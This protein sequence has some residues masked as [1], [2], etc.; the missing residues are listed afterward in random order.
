[1][2]GRFW[3][4]NGIFGVQKKWGKKRELGCFFG[5]VLQQVVW[6]QN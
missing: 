2:N 6:V 1:M 5:A 4:F 3:H